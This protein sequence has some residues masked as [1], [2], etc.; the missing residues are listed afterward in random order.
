MGKILSV[1]NQKGGVG[2]TT[3]SVNLASSLSNI[4]ATLYG[5]LLQAPRLAHI[6]TLPVASFEY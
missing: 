3:T 2:K 4:C 5:G 1:S 6:R